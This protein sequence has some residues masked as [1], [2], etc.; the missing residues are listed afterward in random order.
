VPKFLFGRNELGLQHMLKV[1]RQM[2]A[3]AER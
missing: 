2:V 1:T 3:D